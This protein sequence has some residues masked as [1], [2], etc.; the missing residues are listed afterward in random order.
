MTLSE[1]VTISK[2]SFK[3]K[4]NTSTLNLY[5][6]GLRMLH[7]SQ[8]SRCIETKKN[9]LKGEMKTPVAWWRSIVRWRQMIQA[10]KFI[11][12]HGIPSRFQEEN[13]QSW[14]MGLP[15]NISLK[16]KD[17]GEAESY[18]HFPLTSL[19]PCSTWVAGQN[20]CQCCLLEMLKRGLRFGRKAALY[21][22]TAPFRNLWLW[23]Q[24]KV[25]MMETHTDL[26]NPAGW[27]P[28][29]MHLSGVLTAG[30]IIKG[31]YSG[32]YTGITR[33]PKREAEEEGRR[34]RKRCLSACRI[35]KP[36][37]TSVLNWIFISHFPYPKNDLIIFFTK[38]SSWLE[39]F[40]NTT[41]VLECDALR[42]ASTILQKIC[43]SPRSLRCL[44][45]SGPFLPRG[46]QL[47]ATPSPSRSPRAKPTGQS[48]FLHQAKY[49]I[50]I[51]TA[52][53]GKGNLCFGFCFRLLEPNK[54]TPITV[55]RA[56]SL[57]ICG[58]PVNPKLYLSSLRL[59]LYTMMLWY[60]LVSSS[61]SHFAQLLSDKTG[62][63]HS[64]FCMHSSSL[65]NI[66]IQLLR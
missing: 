55:S 33:V 20:E 10:A 43:G 4:Y 3:K 22:L 39:V 9:I 52:E 42:K 35:H 62:S 54:M 66:F 59:K 47:T 13:Q 6:T 23:S 60:C 37:F 32:I 31:F 16:L 14:R 29:R 64:L 45:S 15:V 18:F 41:M 49:H 1:R 21:D 24:S 36:S 8:I 40:L 56:K 61:V 46:H 50:M 27:K 44:K 63:R 57:K 12:A 11:F 2:A 34:T 19:H 48:I 26:G 58:L 38:A 25:L 17:V 65:K 51:V 5:P 30:K 53:R 7:S 28:Q